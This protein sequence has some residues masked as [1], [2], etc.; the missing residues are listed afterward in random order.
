MNKELW[1]ATWAEIEGVDI[2][3][4]GNLNGKIY[5]SKDEAWSACLEEMNATKKN[6]PYAQTDVFSEGFHCELWD[7]EA[8]AKFVWEIQRLTFSDEEGSNL[9]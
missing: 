2:R 9:S 8:D 6:F 4:F 1:V 5:K 3:S 7:D